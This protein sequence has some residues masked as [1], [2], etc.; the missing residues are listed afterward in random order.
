MTW[1]HRQTDRPT[2]RHNDYGNPRCT[3]APRVNHAQ[4]RTWRACFTC[5][6]K[7]GPGLPWT[8]LLSYICTFLQ[9]QFVVLAETVSLSVK[10]PSEG[11]L[12][13]V[14]TCDVNMEFVIIIMQ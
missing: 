11:S 5:Q 7:G 6:L 12:K 4:C 10:L 9:K 3:C 1:T 14:I 8:F 13:L 2:D